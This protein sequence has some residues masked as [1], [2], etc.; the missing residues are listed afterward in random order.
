MLDL[1]VLSHRRWDFVHQRPRQLMSCLS[2]HYSVHYLEEPVRDDGPA[3]L[4]AHAQG[5]ALDVL[6]PHTPLAA[7]G[8][9]DAQMPLIAPLLARHLRERRIDDYIAWFYTPMALPLLAALR[10]RLVVYDCM[11]ELSALRAAPRQIHLRERALLQ[12]ATL[13][14]ASGPALY[15]AKRALHPALHCLPSAVD[16]AHFAPARLDPDSADAREAE[17]LQAGLPWPRL[18]FFGVVDERLDMALVDAVAAARPDWQIVMAGPVVGIDAAALPMRPNIHWLG[19]QPYGRLPY[20]LAGWDLCLM[21]Y[22]LNDTTRCLSPT[23]T[24][25]YMAGGKPVVSTPVPDV[26]ALHGDVVELAADAPLFIRACAALLAETGRQRAE[27][28]NNMLAAVFRASWQSTALCVHTL[29]Q[30]ALEVEPA[31]GAIWPESGP[32]LAAAG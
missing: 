5:P 10:P 29:I 2:R 12:R 31:H 20:L 23:Q 3:W 25:E 1:I 14:F 17:R 30:R 28:S 9:D 21:P 6:V 26:V 15:E 4:D 7:A 13:V 19:V 16:P 24:L 11:D 22:A 8:F 27:R 32:A 18:G